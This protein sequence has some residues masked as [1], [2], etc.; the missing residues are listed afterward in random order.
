MAKNVLGTDLQPCSMNPRTGWFRDGCCNTGPG[1]TGLHLICIK[2]TAEFLAFSQRV[3]NDLS[4]P[5]PEYQFAGV[6][7]G[8][9]WC[10]CITRWVEAREAGFAPP[11]VLEATHMSSLEF[12]TLDELREYEFKSGSNNGEDDSTAD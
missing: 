3:G 8:D 6:K 11:V 5:R 4:T 10:L 9:Q 12:A 7:P 1:D 2:A